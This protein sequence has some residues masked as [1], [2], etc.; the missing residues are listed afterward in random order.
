[1]SIPDMTALDLQTFDSGVRVEDDLVRT[2]TNAFS[3][4]TEII[5]AGIFPGKL[6]G[7]VTVWR[8]GGLYRISHDILA[9]QG[10]GRQRWHDRLRRNR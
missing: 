8:F 6:M 2:V 7:S 5:S 1:M 9:C 10:A 3:C 4:Q